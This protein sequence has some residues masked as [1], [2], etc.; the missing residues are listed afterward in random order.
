MISFF[1]TGLFLGVIF[2][3]IGVILGIWAAYRYTTT[4]SD[5]HFLALLFW[6]IGL[7]AILVE[8]LAS[9]SP[10]LLTNVIDGSGGLES[11]PTFMSSMLGRVS[12]PLIVSLA[13]IRVILGIFKYKQSRPNYIISGSDPARYLYYSY[14][15]YFLCCGLINSVA[16]TQPAFVHWMFYPVLIIGAAYFSRTWEMN[17]LV[18]NTKWILLTLIYLSLLAAI[19]FPKFSYETGYKGLIPGLSIRLYGLAAHPNTLGPSA[20]LFLVLEYFYPSIGRARFLHRLAAISVILLAQSKTA[21]GASLVVI[22]IILWYKTSSMGLSKKNPSLR[23]SFLTALLLITAILG[24]GMLAIDLA[25]INLANNPFSYLDAQEIKYLSTL[26]GR[27]MIWDITL[28]EWD[29]NPLFG[30]GPTIW[31]PEFR[32]KY[33]LLVVGQAHNQFI[34]ALGESGIIGLLGLVIYILFLLKIALSTAAFSHGFSLALLAIP[35]LRT[36]TETPFRNF[37]INDW[38]FFTH[39]LVISMLMNL[40]RQKSQSLRKLD[41]N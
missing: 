21:Y 31:Y 26:T 20:L 5:G 32:A 8:V 29:K 33:G 7:S 13:S 10:S 16:G 12:A 23:L 9:R 25:N 18:K 38:A 19:S 22:F 6:L 2:A 28:A 34:Q 41:V 4:R 37:V 14:L 24:L 17:F 27:T 40:L 11:T 15:L 35:L 3:G 1:A 36:W 39:L 30:Y